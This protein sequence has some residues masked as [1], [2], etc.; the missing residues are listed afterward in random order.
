MLHRR[1][2]HASLS[3]TFHGYAPVNASTTTEV[4]IVRSSSAPNGSVYSIRFDNASYLDFLNVTTSSHSIRA[5]NV[6]M[7]LAF[8]T[9]S[10][11]AAGSDIALFRD[12]RDMKQEVD[13]TRQGGGSTNE[14][15]QRRASPPRWSP[16][17]MFT[18]KSK[19]LDL[20]EKRVIDLDEPESGEDSED[21]VVVKSEPDIATPNA[22]EIEM[23]TSKF[24]DQDIDL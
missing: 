19:S 8:Q 22:Y 10:N 6:S 24:S 18:G 14:Y 2:G 1:V 16:P 17:P 15:W 23:T 11:T 13:A 21:D 9:C 5:Y 3:S 4:G 7:V 20:G 12:Q